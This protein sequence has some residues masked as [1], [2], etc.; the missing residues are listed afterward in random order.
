V[1]GIY[2]FVLEDATRSPDTGSLDL[3][4]GA[5]LAFVALGLIWGSNFIFMK[6][7]SETISPAQITFLRVLCGFLPILAY[8]LARRTLSRGHLRH[9][10]HFLVMSLL[11]TSFYY[12]AF[13]TGSSLLPSGIAGA[14]SGAIPLFAFLSAASFL[15][16]ERITPLRALG[17]FVGF[18]GVLLIAHPW[19]TSGTVN[20]G[21][22]LYILLGSLSVGLSFVYARKFSWASISQRRR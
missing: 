17:V 5:T 18:C 8:A 7:A 6:R 20:V 1:A 19:S 11:A 9:A 16:S 2:A 10:H 4:K 12:F 22:V 3:R 13:A 14:L 15:P 21:G